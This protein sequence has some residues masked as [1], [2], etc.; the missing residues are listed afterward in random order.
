MTTNAL[1]RT[2]NDTCVNCGHPF[3]RTFLGFDC[4]P[5][6][7]FQPEP[8]IPHEEAVR[9]INKEPSRKQ[10]GGGDGWQESTRGGAETLTLEG[11]SPGDDGNDLFVQK[12][13]DAA[14]YIVPEE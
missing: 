10:G 11:P 14:N 3:I 8:S 5:L 12:M 7:E 9:L 4:L 2:N 1:L 13:L 6:V